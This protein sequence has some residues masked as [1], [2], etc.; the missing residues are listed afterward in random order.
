MALHGA[1]SIRAHGNANGA[2]KQARSAARAV[3]EDIQVKTKL[4]VVTAALGAFLGS[5]PLQHIGVL[6]Q[7]VV[8]DASKAL[9]KAALN[10][11]ATP[12]FASCGGARTNTISHGN[13]GFGNG[14]NDGVP[15]NSGSAPGCAGCSADSVR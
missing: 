15:G 13:N 2:L 1:C 9:I 7:T 6:P 12:A 4:L 8:G 11:G 10:R 14:G 5:G 3:D